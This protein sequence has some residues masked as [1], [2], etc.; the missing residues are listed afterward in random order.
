MMKVYLYDTTLRDGA[1]AEGINYTV[2]DKL[3]I[4][5]KL[6]S[7][8][9]DYL[10]GGWPG[11]NPKDLEFF[12]EAKK[13]DF[14]KT[15]L[16]AF[17]ST[18]HPRLKVK[19]DPNLL[20]LI[21]SEAPVVTVFG[22]SWDLHVESALATT[23]ENNL[24]MVY[25]TVAF[26]KEVGREV[27][28]DAEHFFDGFKNNPE[29]ALKVIEQAVRAGADFIVLCDTN[30]GSLPKEIRA[31]VEAALKIH[32]RIGIH[33]HNDSEL[34]VANSLIAV[35]AGATMVQGTINGYGERCGNANLCSVIPNLILKMG[36][37]VN[38]QDN[39]KNLTRL[40]R[41]VAEIA[42]L[43]PNPYQPYTGQSAFTHKGGVHASAL[44]K[45]KGTY[46]HIPPELVGN[47]RKV[48]ISD[49]AGVS[50]L[51]FNSENL[52]LSEEEVKTYGKELVAAIKAME[53][54]GY[55]FEGAEASLELLV[56]K[57]TGKL[58]EPFK[59]DNSKLIIE[60]KEDGRVL[61]E[62]VVKVRVGDTTI[63]TASDGNGPV[64][65]LDNALRK[66]LLEIYPNL[67]ELK[68]TDYKV[69]VLNEKAGTEAVVRV[70]IE[71]SA[72]EKSINTV[73]VS[74]NII[75]AS[76]KALTDSL[77]YF[78]INNNEGTVS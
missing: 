19:D 77:I 73:G 26:L 56:R 46:E 64:N 63:H 62:A 37:E 75:E 12:Q 23:L 32:P 68:L 50:N 8:G 17:G 59:I 69:R 76:L 58:S 52:G 42:N 54:Q 45:D 48:S 53:H 7:F 25:E 15:K 3:K 18:R 47:H 34:A 30:G 36:V 10:E 51:L 78:L 41:Y 39:L 33:A 13:L 6:I 4:A 55:Q 9:I 40:S 61:S 71:S 66:A 28:F 22:K 16:A 44:L 31:G 65:A 21:K 27:V 67:S 38:C 74:T 11:A 49:Q 2:S 72:G 20:N 14:N 1:Q 70:L 57:V 24:L 29:Y 43:H 35:E 5:R 60:I